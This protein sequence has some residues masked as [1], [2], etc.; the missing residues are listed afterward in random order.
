M[1][2]F[3]LFFGLLTS[4]PACTAQKIVAVTHNDRPHFRIRTKTATYYYDVAGGGFSSIVDPDGNDW[5]AYA[6]EPWGEYPASAASSYRGVPNFVFREPDNGAGHPGWD[7]CESRVVGRRKIHTVSK[8]G[9]WA[10]TVTFHK[11]CARFDMVRSDPDH[12]YWFLYEGPA[13]GRYRPETTWWAT[14]KT[15][16]SYAVQDHYRGNDHEGRHRYMYFG[17]DST[18]RTLFIYQATP[19]T[20]LD[21]YSLL[22]NTEAGA[23][24]SPDGMIV[25]G[26]GRGPGSYPLMTGPNTFLIGIL[27]G[28]A[29]AGEKIVK[30]GRRRAK[31]TELTEET[32]H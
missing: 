6:R 10:W 8:S 19:D 18:P 7:E 21:H 1:L 26:L 24:E 14:D 20:L 3:L 23:A 29:G 22:G 31:R 4:A 28:A 2:R 9:R 11:D 15:P 13:G 27:G 16:K 5:V 32:S 12:P 17:E 25:A 30:I